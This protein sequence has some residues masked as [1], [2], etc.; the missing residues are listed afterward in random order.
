MTEP[1]YNY[2]TN[3]AYRLLNEF[4][5]YSFPTPIF[6]IIKKFSDIK[7]LS[8][9]Q[10]AK[11]QNITY[12]QFYSLASSEYGFSKKDNITNKT[13]ILYNDKKDET[14]IRF[15][16]AHELAHY[17]LHHYEDDYAEDKEANCFA[18]NILCPVPIIQEMGISTIKEYTEAFKVSEPMANVAIQMKYVDSINIT[19]ENYNRF[20]DN[21]ICH[22]YGITLA[23]LYG[24]SPQ[25][26]RF[27]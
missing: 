14:V 24:Y 15:T 13:L 11:K 3:Q 19:K 6:L 27:A 12:D 16:L 23:D 4:S 1:N 9:T 18:R 21:V 25:N 5:V 20:N 7:L 8:Y 22:Y 17:Y 10:V 2:A 26:Y